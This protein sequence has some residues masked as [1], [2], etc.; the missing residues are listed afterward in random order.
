MPIAYDCVPQMTL[1]SSHGQFQP[2]TK[3]VTKK[4]KVKNLEKELNVMGVG[5]SRDGIKWGEE[6]RVRRTCGHVK[7]V[8]EQN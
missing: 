8:H 6:R 5:S 4:S 2:K 3:E 1:T 7:T